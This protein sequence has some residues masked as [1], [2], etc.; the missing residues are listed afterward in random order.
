MINDVKQRARVS[1]P[2]VSLVCEPILETLL[3]THYQVMADYAYT[4]WNADIDNYTGCVPR[5]AYFPYRRTQLQEIPTKKIETPVTFHFRAVNSQTE[6][7]LPQGTE[8]VIDVYAGSV[9]LG[10]VRGAEGEE[11]AVVVDRGAKDG[12]LFRKDTDIVSTE[13]LVF[14]LR[15]Q[16]YHLNW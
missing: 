3:S 13:P 8:V 2:P 5:Q 12:S 10:E 9:L 15:Y 14:T 16:P 6:D 1:R 7:G 11:G 4:A